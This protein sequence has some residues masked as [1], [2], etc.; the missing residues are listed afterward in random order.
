MEYELISMYHKVHSQSLE[1]CTCI[2]PKVSIGLHYCRNGLSRSGNEYGPLTDRPDWTFVGMTQLLHHQSNVCTLV[3]IF[4]WQTTCAR[5]GAEKKGSQTSGIQCELIII[6]EAL[7]FAKRK[8]QL[9]A[10]TDL[11]MSTRSAER[12]E[13]LFEACVRF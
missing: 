7:L 12:Q 6:A 9:Y 1:H 3:S 4:R 13:W 2:C 10:C 11:T 8:N 5:Q